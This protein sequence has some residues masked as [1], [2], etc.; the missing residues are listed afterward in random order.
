M[1]NLR[2][3]LQSNH[4]AGTKSLGIFVT[5]GFPEKSASLP[6]LNAI[7][8]GGADFIELGMPFSDPLAEGIPI[9]RS[10]EAALLGG[11]TMNDTF[12]VARNFRKESAT[13]LV[14]MGYT[15][16]V[17]HYGISNFFETAHSSGVDAV[18]LPDLS[19]E[20]SAPYREAARAADVDLVFLIAPTT[21]D[22]RI[23]EIDNLSSG[24]VYA[25]SITGLTGN[26]IDEIGAVTQYLERVKTIVVKNPLLVGF[27]ISSH[28][29][30]VELSR[31]TQGCIV[32]SALI[33]KIEHLW[34]NSQLSSSE[35]LES[36]Q[37]FIHE[38]KNGS[39]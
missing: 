2:R 1:S 38:L 22:D 5:C 12:G 20:E 21:P 4:E 34:S 7:D 37:S 26:Q 13:P 10:S 32:G 14:L 39:S 27:G 36:I 29:D 24:F 31:H 23:R 16:P 8:R 18:I 19:P 11:I 9:Q 30:A 6:I 28:D 3:K 33:N 15:N 35:R 17:L 25:V